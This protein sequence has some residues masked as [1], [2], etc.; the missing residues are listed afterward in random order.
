MGESDGG[1]RAGPDPA[2]R[3]LDGSGSCFKKCVVARMC[4]SSEKNDLPKTSPN[5]SLAK[6]L[7][8]LW[9]HLEEL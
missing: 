1:G 6:V 5:P 9:K 4:N 7:G 2:S 8:E 3:A